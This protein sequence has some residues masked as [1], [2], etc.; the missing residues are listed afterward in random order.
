METNTLVLKANTLK[1]RIRTSTT[2]TQLVAATHLRNRWYYIYPKGIYAQ[3][4]LL[5][6]KGTSKRPWKQA[7]AKGELSATHT[8]SYQ[9]NCR[10]LYCACVYMNNHLKVTI[11]GKVLNL[12]DFW[13]TVVDLVGNDF[14]NLG[15]YNRLINIH[16]SWITEGGTT[17][18]AQFGPWE[19]VKSL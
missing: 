15:P 1:T 11:L 16:K 4:H 3:Q 2:I 18:I 10:R 8:A 14:S 17:S 6:A 19:S 7:K 13:S 12:G 5:C 9:Q